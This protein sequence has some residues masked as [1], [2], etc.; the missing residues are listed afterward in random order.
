MGFKYLLPVACYQYVLPGTDN[1][2]AVRV[3]Y[4]CELEVVIIDTGS[5]GVC[6]WGRGAERM[7]PLQHP[8]KSARGSE[9]ENCGIF[10]TWDLRKHTFI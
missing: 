3:V 4:C 6:P 5:T 9:L 7:K 8:A 2:V 1:N 10:L